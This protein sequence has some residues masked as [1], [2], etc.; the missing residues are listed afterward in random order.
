MG[1]LEVFFKK[2]E[3]QESAAVKVWDLYL[4]YLTITISDLRLWRYM[5]EASAVVSH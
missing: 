2:L 1:S 3:E 4:D 5:Q